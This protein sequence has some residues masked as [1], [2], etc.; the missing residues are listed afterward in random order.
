MQP[1][2][3]NPV[4]S[5]PAAMKALIALSTAA[6]ASGVPKSTLD[7]VHLR[8]SQINSCAVCVD[9]HARDLKRGG[10]TDERV[11]SVSAWREAPYY[12]DAERAALGLAEGMTRLADQA[13]PV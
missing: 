6:S 2:I 9:M 12:T 3:T 7:L 1:R 5:V 4:L 11:F 13:D 8:A 10:A